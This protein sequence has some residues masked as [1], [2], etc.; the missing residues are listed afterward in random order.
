MDKTTEYVISQFIHR[1]CS[2]IDWNDAL[3]CLSV[4]LPV[5][6]A[7]PYRRHHPCIAIGY[8]DSDIA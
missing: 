5:V 3:L 4:G 7:A 1:L 2:G 8:F 6:D